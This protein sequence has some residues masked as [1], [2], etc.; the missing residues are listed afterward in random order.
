MKTAIKLSALLLTG[1]MLTA[2]GSSSS[3]ISI[4]PSSESSLSIAESS[5]SSEAVFDADFYKGKLQEEHV[6]YS[7][8]SN[9][10]ILKGAVTY[11][12]SFDRKDLYIKTVDGVE[13][14]IERFFGNADTMSGLDG[15][16]ET[17][18]TEYD[19]YKTPD[20]TYTKGYD[21]RY[22]LTTEKNTGFNTYDIGFDFSKASDLSV[23]FSGFEANLVG[24]VADSDLTGFFEGTFISGISGFSFKANLS[25][26]E[27]FINN[28]VI[29]YEQKGFSVSMAYQYSTTMTN[30]T[31]P[32][33]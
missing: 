31:L 29:S 28:L 21:N 3:I 9:G 4:E 11:K 5:S 10:S 32:V 30:I 6:F 18:H 13:S 1:L 17:A 2:C 15:N 20:S 25:K 14:K 16:Q 23:S 26:V 27:G 7:V 33:V 12:T 22:A 19:I 24:K 8:R